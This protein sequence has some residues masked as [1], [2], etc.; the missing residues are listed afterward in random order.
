MIQKKITLLSIVLITITSSLFAQSK[1]NDWGWNWR[2]SSKIAA[3]NIPQHKKFLK[4][5]FPYPA[6]PNDKMELGVSAGYAMLISDV[7]AD[8]RGLNNN[9]AF[10]LGVTLRKSISHT[11]S[12]RAGYNYLNMY[13]LDWKER[14]GGKNTMGSSIWDKMYNGKNYFA[15][16]RNKSH[17]LSFDLI[18]SLTTQD[19]Y[20]GNP[21]W[22]VYLFGGYTFLASKVDVNALDANGNLWDFNSIVRVPTRRAKDIVQDQRTAMSEGSYETNAALADGKRGDL[23]ISNNWFGR[24]AV[25]AGF[26]ISYK[27]NKKMNIGFEQKYTDAF[28][29][30]LDGI[31][32]GANDDIIS[33]TSFHFNYNIGNSA[34]KIEPL[35]WINPSNYVYNELNEP[36]HMKLPPV[37]LPDADGDG[38]TDQFDLEPNT[39]KGAAVDSHGR[40]LDTDGDGVPDYRDKELLT[41]QACFPV[42]NDG[43]G[44]CPEPPCCSR[45]PE[46][47][48]DTVKEGCSVTNLP[49]IQFGNGSKLSSNSTK[50]LE[51][52]AVKLK[53]NPLCKVNVIGH[54]LADK[55]SQQRSWE[56]VNSIIKYLVEKQGISESRFIFTYDGGVGESNTVDLQAT[57]EE[58]PNTVPAPHPN[59]KAKN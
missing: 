21:K 36:R 1:N 58:G 9:P 34:K 8:W 18:Y 2:D 25:D 27:L 11:W 49:S 22:N 14:T 23:V 10:G 46:V 57:T 16:F 28:C 32:E 53:A 37:V 50:L 43:V 59:L 42:N 33:Y 48:K 4:N 29:D 52:V 54:P 6:R 7:L 51:V 41:P 3:K 31:K 38:V 56:R 15:N 5:E 24:H 44:V 30:E 20:R 13:G 17:S 12:V 55:A 47:K 45:I 35:W 39:P 26:G 19:Y 40:A